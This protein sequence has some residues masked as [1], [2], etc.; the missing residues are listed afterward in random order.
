M[1]KLAGVLASDGVDGLYFGLVSH[2][3]DP[4][5]IVLGSSEPPT[6]LADP[7]A[8]PALASPAARMMFFDALTYLP[9]DILTKLDRATMGVGLE[10]RIPLLDHR[11]VEFA[12]R[13]PLRMKIRD[14]RGKWL[15]RRVV[16]RYVPDELI[17]RPK[18]GFGIPIASWLRGPLRDWAE[19]L[20][21]SHRLSREGILDP[22]PIRVLW[23][24]HL[25]GKRNWQY[26]LW[27]VLMFQSWAEN[28]RATSTAAQVAGARP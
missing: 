15:L 9:D 28:W 5:A 12:W 23:T 11:V 18:M 4:E 6:I 8:A 21:D 25:S 20:L 24:E 13:L 19:D 17:D 3:K 14:G 22:D 7:G 10:G 1:Q 26:H 16:D 2:W 27:D